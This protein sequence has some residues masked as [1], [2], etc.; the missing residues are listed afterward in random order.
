MSN[1]KA[2]WAPLTDKERESVNAYH[3]RKHKPVHTPMPRWLLI[4]N[5]ALMVVALVVTFTV[6]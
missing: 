3:N 5:I 1:S 6:A 4:A 2:E